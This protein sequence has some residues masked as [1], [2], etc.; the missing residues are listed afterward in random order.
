MTTIHN[1]NDRN[2]DVAIME[3]SDVQEC[4]GSQL[5]NRKPKVNNDKM[6]TQVS[7]KLETRRLSSSSSS[8]SGTNKSDMEKI[9]DH[10][11]QKQGIS[12]NLLSAHPISLIFGKDPTDAFLVLLL[13]LIIV[14]TLLSMCL[15]EQMASL[16]KNTAHLI[17]VEALMTSI[18]MLC[19]NTLIRI[20][21]RTVILSGLLMGM[22]TILF[23]NQGYHTSNDRVHVMSASI[24][25]LFL[26]PPYLGIFFN[27]ILS[28]CARSLVQRELDDS[29]ICTKKKMVEKYKLHPFVQRMF[30]KEENEILITGI[31]ISC[32]VLLNSYLLYTNHYT[33]NWYMIVLC[34]TTFCG[35]AVSTFHVQVLNAMQDEVKSDA[36]LE[37]TGS[38]RPSTVSTISSERADKKNGRGAPIT[39]QRSSLSNSSTV[40]DAYF[41]PYLWPR[42]LK[43]TIGAWI[44]IG[45]LYTLQEC[46]KH[47]GIFVYGLV[48]CL[49]TGLGIVPFLIMPSLFENDKTK[50]DEQTDSAIDNEQKTNNLAGA[51]NAIAAGTMIAAS[52]GLGVEAGEASEMIFFAEVWIGFIVGALFVEYTQ[53]ILTAHDKDPSDLLQSLD[54]EMKDIT[55]ILLFVTVM[56][57]HSIAEGVA[58]GVSFESSNSF[59]RYVTFALTLHNIPEGL[60]IALVLLPRGFSKPMT[61]AIAIMSSAP[62][63]LMAVLAVA[64]VEHVKC[65]LPYALAFAAGAMVYVSIFEVG[66]EAIEQ[67]G[68]KKCLVTGT[69][70]ACCMYGV[71]IVL[72][73]VTR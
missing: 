63:P 73:G 2:V 59:G 51:A 55:K 12:H 5:T 40:T 50:N 36:H 71:Q 39:K 60:A 57:V 43:T 44:V 54:I 15:P 13:T 24:L 61:T 8:S 66:V 56:F 64:F 18:T 11:K 17:A 34:I 6:D 4:E 23:F 41:W 48:T 68:R 38:R 3:S 22:I 72:H 62:Q 26:C 30:L 7:S 33:G 14:A 49:S 45:L 53:K 25:T 27:K 1:E 16:E 47:V 21:M 29:K 20:P 69:I 19:G 65:L 67:V 52:I 37:I 70:A 58:C 28:Y 42:F 9:L 31:L 46:S 10:V 35:V 32:S